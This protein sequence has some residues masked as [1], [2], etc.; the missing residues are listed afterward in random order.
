[1][2]TRGHTVLAAVI[3]TAML[4]ACGPA[5]TGT[6]S[7]ADSTTE[8]APEVAALVALYHATDGE[9][10]TVN[11]NW[12]TDAP[13]GTWYGVSVDGEGRV[14]VLGLGDNR[15]TGEIPPELGNLVNLRG[16][17]LKDNQLTGE[18]P[19]ELGNLVNLVLLYLETTS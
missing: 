9:S 14:L 3:L 15:L 2:S 8:P 10:W 13:I 11:D 12:L 6:P 5:S 19:P 4:L 7:L 17:D 16:L 1:M 18:I